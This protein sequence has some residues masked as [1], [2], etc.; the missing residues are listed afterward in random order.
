MS[1]SS[2]VLALTIDPLANRYQMLEQATFQPPLNRADTYFRPLDLS[3][4]VNQRQIVEIRVIFQNCCTA[5]A[6]PH[7][8]C[9]ERHMNQL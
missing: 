4:A 8:M 7:L 6:L 5:V 1:G 2:A 3:S 9:P